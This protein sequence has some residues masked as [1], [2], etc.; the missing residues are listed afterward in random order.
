MTKTDEV[1]TE[2]NETIIAGLQADKL[3]WEK[4]WEKSLQKNPTTGKCYSGINSMYL[5]CMQAAKGFEFSA[6]MTYKQI[7]K[8]GGEVFKGSKSSKVLFYGMVEKECK[9]TGEIDKFPVA[10]CYSVFNLDQ[11]SGL[12]SVKIQIEEDI[13][14]RRKKFEES[15]DCEQ[16]IKNTKANIEHIM[17]NK[18]CYI[19]SMDKI[20]MP[21]KEQFKTTE[22]YY[23]TLFHELTHWSGHE[24]RLKRDIKNSF[25]S[26]KYA[27]EELVAEIGASYVC[28]WMGFDYSTQHTA[29]ISDWLK[30]LNN[31]KKAIFKAAAKAQ[32]A[33]NYLWE[34]GKLD[35]A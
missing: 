31:D 25:G 32:K 14:S 2:I 18:A 29:Y 33:F 1:F 7:A 20:S 21:K 4:P 30:L 16:L 19:P 28:A 17:S 11:T 5:S 3:P 26:E 8:I 23:S 12:D 22:D 13:L 15:D 24:S 35:A 27:F 6:W 10:R 9:K 34:E